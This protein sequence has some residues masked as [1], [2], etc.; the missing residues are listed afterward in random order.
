MNRIL[1]AAGAVALGVPVV[2]GAVLAVSP[3]GSQPT[4]LA[5]RPSGAEDVRSVAY[6]RSVASMTEGS[7][8]VV[9]GTVTA[10]A[11]VAT[12]GSDEHQV[13][14]K[15]VTLAVNAVLAGQSDASQLIIEEDGIASAYSEVG[16]RGVYFLVQRRDRDA[17]IYRLVNYQGRYLD[18]GTG[19]LQRSGV[20]DELMSSLEVLSLDELSQQVREGSR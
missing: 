14:R 3:R 9:D 15:H 4:P 19:R 18:D 7:H 10:I 20:E 16:D 17:G 6:F 1:L 13:E 12:L 2:L 8:L 5:D 11:V